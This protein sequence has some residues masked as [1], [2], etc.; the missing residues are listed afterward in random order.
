MGSYISKLHIN[1]IFSLKDF[2]ITIA[3]KDEEQMNH[4]IITGPNGT[5]KTI[6]ITALSKQLEDLKDNKAKGEPKIEIEF[7]NFDDILKQYKTNNFLF[8][9]YKATR[10]IRMEEP[11]RLEKHRFKQSQKIDETMTDKF[12][13]YLVDLKTQESFA[14]NENNIKEAD[15]I[16]DWFESFQEILRELMEDASLELVFD[17]RNYTFSIKSLGKVFSFNELSDGYAAILDIVVDIIFRMHIMTGLRNVYDIAG[18]VIVDEIETHLH[19]SLQ[20]HALPMLTT[21]FPNIQF[22]VT[23][24]S[25]LVL[26]SIKNASVFDLY[27][28]RL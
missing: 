4:L 21:L 1:Q 18:I 24:H 7:N 2:D 23:T 20:Q 16:K 11:Q 27:P 6:L 19:P 17:Y 3:E 14:R 26:A 22:I 25:P 8:A 10:N 28:V 5:G 13:Y 12:L 15:G 9:F